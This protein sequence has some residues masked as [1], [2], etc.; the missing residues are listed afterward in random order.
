MRFLKA[1][2]C[3]VLGTKPLRPRHSAMEDRTAVLCIYST[4]HI[5]LGTHTGKDLS[6]LTSLI[7]CLALLSYSTF[8][9]ILLS[10]LSAN[11]T[12]MG[13]LAWLGHTLFLFVVKVSLSQLG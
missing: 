10:L 6:P 13:H 5:N 7:R 2:V 9:A 1:S 12:G 3:Q 4:M 11:F 8:M